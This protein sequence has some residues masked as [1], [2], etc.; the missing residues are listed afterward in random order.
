[1]SSLDLLK[2]LSFAYDLNESDDPSVSLYKLIRT[3]E[4]VVQTLKYGVKD[5]Q[6][7]ISQE[8]EIR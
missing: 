3:Q 1:M 7:A 4:D 6:Y 2:S 8:I 5:V